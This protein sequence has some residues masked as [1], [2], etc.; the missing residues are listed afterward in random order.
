MIK[1]T[2][3]KKNS[4]ENSRKKQRQLGMI[5]PMLMKKNK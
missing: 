1:S 5:T 4:Q 2:I 3:M